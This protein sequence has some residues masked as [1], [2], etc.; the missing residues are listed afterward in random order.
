MTAGMVG[1]SSTRSA[2]AESDDLTGIKGIGA[3]RQ[4]L[5]QNGLG[6]YRFRDLAALSSQDV[7][8]HLKAAGQIV[9]PTE[10][11]AW[12][13]EAHA[14][15]A[16]ESQTPQDAMTMNE[17]P[18]GNET[19]PPA[20]WRPFA[21]FV[22]EFRQRSVGGQ[23]ERCTHVHHVEADID[24]EWPGMEGEQLCSWIVE[25]IQ[26]KPQPEPRL[27]LPPEPQTREEPS[28]A[29]PP[30]QV[31]RVRVLQPPDTGE[32]AGGVQ[33]AEWYRFLVKGN[34]PFDLEVFL[35]L[36][37]P[38]S[39]EAATQNITYRVQTEAR[40][41]STGD[42]VILGKSEPGVLREGAIS[43]TAVLPVATLQPGTYSLRVLATLDS[44]PPRLGY[45]EIPL[46][47]VV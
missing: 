25:H 39:R 11:A 12:I 14:L 31:T 1:D 24:D 30:V 15:A 36:A 17:Q 8:A 23:V 41:R 28:A 22:V 45:L 5:L 47:Q 27:D 19:P 10:I 13:G 18:D 37:E 16:A 46:L 20:E 29:V 34:E 35:E 3:V 38:L 40:N 21:S 42:R 26:K 6:A 2:G 32:L 44:R 43:Y 33:P 9:S 4:Q 7:E